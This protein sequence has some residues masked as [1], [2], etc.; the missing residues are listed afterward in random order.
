M[1]VMEWIFSVK[2]QFQERVEEWLLL[3]LHCTSDY[4]SVLRPICFDFGSQAD[5]KVV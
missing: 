2:G 1:L 3:F 4:G 5:E